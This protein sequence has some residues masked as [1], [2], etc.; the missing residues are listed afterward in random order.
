MIKYKRI[1][2]ASNELRVLHVCYAP[3][4]ESVDDTREKLQ[5]RR[6]AV[7]AK[8]R[9][10][11]NIQSG[12]GSRL[13]KKT[14]TNLGNGS[15]SEDLA[16]QDRIRCEGQSSSSSSSQKT[17]NKHFKPIETKMNYSLSTQRET[18]SAQRETIVTAQE[19]SI[20]RDTY[21]NESFNEEYNLMLPLPPGRG[22]INLPHFSHG[23]KYEYA[24][25]PSAHASLPVNFDGRLK[26]E[27]YNNDSPSH[28]THSNQNYWNNNQ[29]NY[30][31]K[32]RKE[33]KIDLKGDNSLGFHN[34]QQ[35]NTANNKSESNDPV[36]EKPK[37]NK[38]IVRDYKKVGTA[39]KFVP[40]QTLNLIKK[41]EDNVNDDI[42]K[43]KVTEGDSEK[44]KLINDRLRQNAL[45]LNPK[46]QGPLSLDGEEP[47]LPTKEDNSIQETVINIRKRMNKV[48]VYHVGIVFKSKD[49]FSSTLQSPDS[50][51]KKKKKPS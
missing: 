40:R 19:Q 9:Q 5:D 18:I 26:S 29:Q 30:N 50:P 17:H 32:E 1:Q 14:D 42:N 49:E 16:A 39:P 31:T 8:I 6:K 21:Q 34:S 37:E 44:D 51:T 38:I 45:I 23:S 28:T 20:E 4:F 27:H 35:I 12:T 36:N 33:L 11:A 43:K 13:V 48:Q 7:A 3:E 22:C 41:K 25:V 2:S 15:K 46:P 24:R 47:K 10:H